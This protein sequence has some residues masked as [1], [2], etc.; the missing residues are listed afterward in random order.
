MKFGLNPLA[1]A[2][3]TLS[4]GAHIAVLGA[5]VPDSTGDAEVLVHLVDVEITTG[6]PG[7]ARSQDIPMETRPN[8]ENPTPVAET[9][10]TEM[11]ATDT[12][13]TQANP[14][15]SQA[16]APRLQS[17][18][19]AAETP[20]VTRG[21]TRLEIARLPESGTGTLSTARARPN[22]KPAPQEPPAAAPA[23][24]LVQ[25]PIEEPAQS[26]AASEADGAPVSVA[27]RPPQGSGPSVVV[28]VVPGS[29]KPP[30]YPLAARKRGQEG[31]ALIRAKIGESGQVLGT[32]IIRSSGHPLLDEAANAA[33]AEWQF[34]A[35]TRNGAPVPGRIE[36]P[37]EFRLR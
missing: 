6:P 5:L 33:V 28:Q 20:P 13:A 11:P 29:N 8:P 4:L 12:P 34:R 23:R 3:A 27:A 32:E 24:D 25:E 17:D 15:I 26:P 22:A 35:A 16:R 14:D 1:I 37:I 10:G 7:E 31:T 30:R 2:G 9:S 36:I 18:Q 19:T 21:L